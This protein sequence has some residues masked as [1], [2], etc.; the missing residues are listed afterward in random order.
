[1]TIGISD[2]TLKEPL[3][4]ADVEQLKKLIQQ[5][6]GSLAFKACIW[7]ISDGTVIKC[8]THHL[9]VELGFATV[10]HTNIPHPE[11]KECPLKVKILVIGKHHLAVIQNSKHFRKM[12]HNNLF[13]STKQLILGNQLIYYQ[14][15]Q[16]MVYDQDHSPLYVCNV[17]K[18]NCQEN[19]AAARP[20]SAVNIEHTINSGHTSLAIFLFVFGEA[21]YPTSSRHS[22]SPALQRMDTHLLA[23]T[24]LMSS[25]LD[26][27]TH[28]T[29]GEAVQGY[30]HTHFNG[31]GAHLKSLACF[32]FQEMF[33]H[34][35]GVA[36][37]KAN[38]ICEVLQYSRG[39]LPTFSLL[40]IPVPNLEVDIDDALDK[41]TTGL[42]LELIEVSDHRI[43]DEALQAASFASVLS[44]DVPDLP[45][46]IEDILNECGL[47]AAALN[48]CDLASVDCLLDN[49][50][51]VLESIQATLKP[52]FAAIT[53]L[54]P[55][56]QATVNKL[57][58]G[59]IEHSS[60][61]TPVEDGE[62]TPSV[63]TQ[64]LQHDLTACRQTL[65]TSKIHKT[66]KVSGLNIKGDKWLS[67]ATSMDKA[68]K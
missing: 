18:L 24:S 52:I 61:H 14:Q 53:A 16:S 38:A 26:I 45:K 48:I 28:Q 68:G 56:G 39:P 36:W 66:L 15:V 40:L 4:V 43:L 30:A 35:T 62:E 59:A 50:P 25:I 19:C 17:N 9:L 65:L 49:D 41:P 44:S 60:S 13:T 22:G 27:M 11:H 10:K 47:A 3:I 29:Y 57:M 33:E 7:A 21:C 64:I 32:P 34:I 12:C 31:S 42:N 63:L 8:N 58:K 37:T 51:D 67:T 2:T 54:G 23:T 20:F 46:G 55:E 5:A 1:M 6:L